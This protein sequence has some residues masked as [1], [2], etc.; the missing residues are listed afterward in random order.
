MAINPAPLPLVNGVLYSFANVEIALNG[1]ERYCTSINYK[2][3]VDIADVHA[4]SIKRIGV[5]IKKYSP[6]G[7]MEMALADANAFLADLG[8]G[9]YARKFDITVTYSADGEATITDKLE[10]VRVKSVDGPFNDGE[11]KRKF[12][13]SI[14]EIRWNGVRGLAR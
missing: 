11:I 8:E 2:D 9:F 6:T 5:V 3:A 1:T 10:G 14:D 4:N 12:E 7:D 13:L